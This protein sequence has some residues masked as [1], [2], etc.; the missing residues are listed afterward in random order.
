MAEECFV[1][2][3]DDDDGMRASLSDLLRSVGYGVR[4]FSSAA[5]FLEAKLEEA[6]GCLISDVRLPGG[7]GLDL[8]ERLAR[9]GVGL[10]V[11]LMTG[12]GDIRMSVQGM[13]AGAVDFLE[14]PFRD[15]D[16]LDAITTAL[17]VDRARR[18]SG[19]RTAVLRQRYETLSRREREVVGLVAAGQ[20]NKQVAARLSISEVTVKVH[21]SAGMRKMG[22]NSLAQLARMAELLGLG[23]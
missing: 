5:A 1:Y 18:A 11:I 14:K 19:A 16:L 15:Q 9:E 6:P 2:I 20:M 17:A 4:D 22:A 23:A 21:R 13:K 7:S 12:Y 10:P 3:V 8:Q